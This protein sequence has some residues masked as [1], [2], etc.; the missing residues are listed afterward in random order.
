MYIGIDFGMSRIGIAL[1]ELGQLAKPLCVIKNKG[2]RK[3][4]ALIREICAKY[5]VKTI[6]CGLPLDAEGK[7]TPMS[8]EIERFCFELEKKSGIPVVTSDE[9]YSSKEA[10]DYIRQTKSKDLLDAVAASLVLQEYL[11]K[12]QQGENK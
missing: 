5:K 12:R 2:A 4:I 10:E 11:I 1:S 7:A 6:V 8:H 9:R 3:N